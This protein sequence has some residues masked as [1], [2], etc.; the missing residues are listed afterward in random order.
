MEFMGPFSETGYRLP[1]YRFF[2]REPITVNDYVFCNRAATFFSMSL[3]MAFKA[4]LAETGPEPFQPVFRAVFFFSLN[5]G[6][7]SDMASHAKSFC[8]IC[9]SGPVRS[10]SVSKCFPVFVSIIMY[11]FLSQGFYCLG[12]IGDNEWNSRE[13]P[14]RCQRSTSFGL[15]FL[16]LNVY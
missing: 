8:R 1:V 4:G 12:I 10:R 9:L 7:L 2:N 16:V 6:T 11:A 5:C 13:K 3:Q 14:E 15:M